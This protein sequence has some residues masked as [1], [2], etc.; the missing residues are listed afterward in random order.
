[1]KYILS[2]VIL[3]IFSCKQDP[4][5]PA[6]A[7]N[8]N[9]ILENYISAYYQLNPLDATQNGNMNYNDQLAIDISPDHAQKMLV[10]NKYYL[11]TLATIDTSE[12]TYSEQLSIDI[13]R[14]K[15]EMEVEAFSN[16]Y[17]LNRPVDQFVFSFPQNFATLGSGAGFIPFKTE[18]DYRNFISRMKAFPAWIDQSIEN[19]QAG[20][21]SHNTNPKASMIKVPSQL[22]PLFETGSDK[23]IF[24]KPLANLP[25]NM[26]TAAKAKLI[27]DYSETIEA[28]IKPAYKKLHDYLTKDYIPNTR[29]N[30]GLLDNSNGA[31]EYAFW[32]RYY[33]TKNITA[34]EIFALGESEV[35]RI[36]KEMDSLKTLTGF[37]GDLKA[38]FQFIKTDKKFFPF[39]TEAAVLDRYKSF[40]AFMEPQLKKLFNLRPKMAF[41]V[42]ATEKFRAAGANAQYNLGARDGSRPGIFYETVPNPLAYNSFS[43]ESL[44]IHEAIPGHHFQS[45]LQVEGNLPEF[46]KSYW[47]SAFGE[48]WALYAESLGKE[49][50][51]YTDPYQYMG[52]LNNEIER[53]VRL[54]VDAGMHHKGWTREQAIAYVLEN[55]PVTEE[56]AIQRIERYMVTPGQAVSYKIGELS[57]L[58]MRKK[59]QE[60][61]GNKFD[62]RAFH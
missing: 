44:F 62:I 27:K 8:L 54:V 45:G 16:G 57:I 6:S 41:E 60:K 15:L 31:K 11:D 34:D 3:F 61:L 5:K 24:Y 7:A 53:A 19:M 52:R 39:K 36:R 4:K 56:V 25:A 47:T 20:L 58:A 50:G 32:L 43:M 9:A 38:F 33:T 2:F 49:L 37:K 23:N 35:A 40:E 46:R 22:K 14:F 18:A 51:M 59:A 26:D 30:T 13:L 12:I 1:M 55:Q 42:R 10:L 28:S 17:G 29:P 48:G 21:E